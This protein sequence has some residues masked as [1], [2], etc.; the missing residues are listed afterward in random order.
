M[1]VS[2]WCS[3]NKRYLYAL[4]LSIFW[5]Y[6]QVVLHHIPIENRRSLLLLIRRLAVLSPRGSYAMLEIFM[7]RVVCIRIKSPPFHFI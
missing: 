3:H 7:A 1:G 5:A 4:L 2:I 6:M